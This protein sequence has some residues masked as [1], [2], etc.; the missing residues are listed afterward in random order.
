MRK[1]GLLSLAA[2][3]ALIASD[4]ALSAS[5]QGHASGTASGAGGATTAGPGRAAPGHHRPPT[6]TGV[7][8]TEDQCTTLGGVVSDVS[9]EGI[10]L[11]GKVCTTFDE[12]KKV[13]NV[14]IT[15]TK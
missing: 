11:S 3:I 1:I 15:A 7:A 8:F 10:C 6:V 4:A 5:T 2:A 9:H 14:C 12:S 13:H